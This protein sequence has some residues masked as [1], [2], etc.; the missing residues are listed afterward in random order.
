MEV[1]TF[2]YDDAQRNAAFELFDLIGESA[3]EKKGTV[4]NIYNLLLNN[5]EDMLQDSTLIEQIRNLYVSGLEERR[6]VSLC[7]RILYWH[8]YRIA[9]LPC[10][11][12]LRILVDDLKK[13]LPDTAIYP[14]YQRMREIH[15]N[16]DLFERRNWLYPAL[17]ETYRGL[18]ACLETRLG[19]SRCRDFMIHLFLGEFST[20][21][22]MNL[23]LAEK[24]RVKPEVMREIRSGRWLEADSSRILDYLISFE[25][26][27]ADSIERD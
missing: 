15:D 4:R 20:A 18:I 22:S 9:S 27:E 14:Y 17:T 13:Y 8:S 2:L 23:S 19:E 7:E 16:Y 25:A 10:R 24:N 11:L 6:M 12:E 1:R 26:E 3:L 5:R 21:L